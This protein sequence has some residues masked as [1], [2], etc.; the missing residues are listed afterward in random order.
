MR[1]EYEWCNIWWNRAQDASLP[2]VLLIGDS[3]SVGY[4]DTVIE[5]LADRANVDRLGT[6]KCVI[7]PAFLAETAYVLGQYGSDS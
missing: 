4:T 3:V 7:D 5:L 1:E 6:S 2:R